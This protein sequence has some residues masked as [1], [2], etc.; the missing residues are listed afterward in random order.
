MELFA[1]TLQTLEPKTREQ[2]V[3]LKSTLWALVSTSPRASFHLLSPLSLCTTHLPFHST[4]LPPP[5]PALPSPPLAGHF[6]VMDMLFF[7][8]HVGSTNWGINFLVE[9][10]VIP[11]IV[12][13]AEECGNFAIR[14]YDVQNISLLIKECFQ[15]VSKSICDARIPKML[16]K[17]IFR[18]ICSDVI[19]LL[20]YLLPITD[21]FAH[22]VHLVLIA[23]SVCHSTE[24]KDSCYCADFR[25][26]N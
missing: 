22:Q 8:G 25:R 9:E 5:P 2:V 19:S 21:F 11:E 17:Y 12:R 16:N 1:R 23:K 24:I 7:Q 4:N 6:Q 13:L 15:N 3:E 26:L 18:F 20:L 14:G 10:A